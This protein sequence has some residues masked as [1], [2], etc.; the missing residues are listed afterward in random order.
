MKAKRIQ[1]LDRE[2]GEVLAEYRS[3]REAAEKNYLAF[4]SVGFAA[5]GYPERTSGGWR[6]RYVEQG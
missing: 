4:P 2:T 5:R 6:W 3:A 1:K